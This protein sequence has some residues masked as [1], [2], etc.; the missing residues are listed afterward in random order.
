MALESSS[1][2]CLVLSNPGYMFCYLAVQVVLFS[3][4]YVIL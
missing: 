2:F 3:W 4:L 1:D